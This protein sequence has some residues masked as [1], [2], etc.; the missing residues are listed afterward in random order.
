MLES[1]QINAKIGR[2]QEEF[3]FFDHTEGQK[4]QSQKSEL[5]GT[6][7]RNELI[8][9]QEKRQSTANVG[10]YG[11][12]PKDQQLS[13]SIPSPKSQSQK[14]DLYGTLPRNEVFEKP[15]TNSNNL[16]VAIPKDET[17]N[18]DSKNFNFFFDIPI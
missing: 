2:I 4:S 7:P 16:Y 8:E 5:Y 11:Q 14:S 10:F 15:K 17:A 12:M 1:T 6:I 18:D 9:E 3:R 13:Q